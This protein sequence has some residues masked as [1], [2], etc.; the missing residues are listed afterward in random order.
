MAEIQAFGFREAAADTVFADGIRLRVFPVEG[1]NPA[2]IEGCL[3]TE[4]DRWVAVAS[5]KAYWSDAW[6][7]GA[8]ATRLGQAVEAERQVYRAYRAG[9][10]QEDQWQRS[11]RM[12]WKVM[13]RCRAILDSAEVGALAAVES[14]EEMGVDWRERIAVA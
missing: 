7:Q 12:F 11:F 14:V 9:R 5:P 6:D 10:I 2:V 1:T 8:F 3:V 4:R 13:I